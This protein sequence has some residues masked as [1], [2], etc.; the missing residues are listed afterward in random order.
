MKDNKYIS[1]S[2]KQTIFLFV[3]NIALLSVGLLLKNIQ[4]DILSPEDYG[5]YAFFT[6]II[7][8]IVLFFR[9]GYF[10]SLQVL[11]AEN[12][13]QKKEKQLIGIGFILTLMIGLLFCIC[14][15][16]LSYFIDDIFNASIKNI[17]QV[18]APMCFL[19]VFKQFIPAITIGTNKVQRLPISEIISRILF[20][21]LLITI[22]L[23]MDLS[24]SDIIFFNIISISL[25]VL[26]I[27]VKFQPS[28]KNL[29]ANY[30]L[31]KEKNRTF[32][33][34]LYLGQTAQQT[35]YK[36]DE[37]FITYFVNA[38]QLGYYTLAKFIA[39]P[40]VMMSQAI[41]TAMY[42]KFAHA[43][44]VSSK[45]F[46]INTLWLLTCIIFL[47]FSSAFIVEFIFGTA[48]HETATYVVPIAFAF[49]FQGLYQ[50][51][52]FLSAKSKGKEIRNI[53]LIETV[54]NITGNLMLIPMY[55]VLGAIYAT[56]LSKATHF[57]GLLFY[58]NQY[59]KESKK[60]LSSLSNHE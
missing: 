14:L 58:Y 26:Y 9:F 36:F 20:L 43:S 45:V 24:L 8:F 35:T 23:Y 27:Y 37:I 31:L 21:V 50:P 54:M 32:G 56:I 18:F 52:S 30:S 57:L 10:S 28:F 46:V 55:G 2:A 7:S 1:T 59:I 16:L 38:T 40:M 6:S 60:D 17:I 25:S 11:L 4:T 3:S 39:M 12:N 29:N 19:F 47:Y 48:Y 22:P 34:Q 15:W 33:F 13:D 41:T 5:L 51:F 49:L 53:A 42:K 44:K